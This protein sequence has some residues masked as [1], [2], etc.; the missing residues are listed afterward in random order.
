MKIA[1]ISGKG[2]TG[3]SCITSDFIVQS[4]S[5]FAI[6]CDVDAANLYLLFDQKIE[7]EESF[8]YGE[9]PSIDPDICRG[10]G[11]C[12]RA[13]H[14]DA[15]SM[16]DGKVVLDEV[17]CEGC[18]LCTRVCPFGAITMVHD[19]ESSIYLGPF[20][21]GY[22]ARAKLYPGE[23][24]SGKLINELRSTG[25]KLMDKMDF[26]NMIMDGPPGIGCPLIS[27]ITG[28][29]LVIIVTEPTR[30]GIEDLKRVTE[31]VEGF[32]IPHTIII[33]KYDLD[34]T[35]SEAIEQWCHEKGIVVA[36]KV[37]FDRKMVD[38]MLAK[39]S[40][41]EYAPDS[42]CALA[43][44][45]SF[46]K[47]L[48]IGKVAPKSTKKDEEKNT[49]VER[50]L[51][52]KESNESKNISN[53]LN[54]KIMPN[55]DATGPGGQGQGTGRGLG[56]CGQ[57][58]NQ[59]GQGQGLGRGQGGRGQGLGRGQGQGGRGQGRGQGQGL[60]RGQGKGQGQG[61]GNQ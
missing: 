23:E 37:P 42:A 11:K 4:K 26:E 55:R 31:V 6:D 56:S 41:S 16:V 40:I 10:C 24:N 19:H 30:S 29:D 5:T 3:K 44:K 18:E 52:C 9:H 34:V 2:G 1:V 7:K 57:G 33:N 46:K 43:L 53:H 22:M 8:I 58:N 35:C 45:E 51:S 50:I 47:S 20:Q 32:D 27:T 48:A 12:V 28:V 17:S 49:N 25:D 38:A 13:C 54:K 21:Y 14:Y 39:K 59:Q 61:R 15:L 60:G 36:G